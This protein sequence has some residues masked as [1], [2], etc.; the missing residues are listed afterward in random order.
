M[1]LTDTAPAGTLRKLPTKRRHIVDDLAADFL[2]VAV[3]SGD[4][5][6]QLGQSSLGAVCLRSGAFHECVA[7]KAGMD[8]LEADCLKRNIDTPRLSFPERA[9]ESFAQQDLDLAVIGGGTGFALLA[10][11][12]RDISQRLKLGGVLLLSNCSRGAVARLADTLYTDPAWAF[13]DMIG[14]EIAVYRKVRMS[15]DDGPAERLDPETSAGAPEPAETAPGL[16][17]GVLRTLFGA[18]PLTRRS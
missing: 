2:S 17:A 7:D 12:W 9:G 13:Q 6:L 4:R 3:K 10:A 14:G 5:S 8:A 11:N 1:T 15:V 18:S 16:L